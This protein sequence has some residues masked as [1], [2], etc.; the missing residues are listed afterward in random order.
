MFIRPKN[1]I[2][3]QIS[4][5]KNLLSILNLGYLPPV[6]QLKKI[7]F[8]ENSET[9]YLTELLFCKKSFLVQLKTILDKKIIF[10]RNYPY[11]SST[12]K[13]LRDN[14]T[15][16][17]NEIR[18]NFNFRKND[19]VV[20]I[21]SNDGNLLDKFKNYFQV[22]G[23]TPESIGKLA[24]KKGIPTLIRY[25]DS[26]AVNLIL[27][28]KG[29]ASII[30]ATNVFAHIDKVHSVVKQIKRLM[31]KD[32]IFVTESHY[33]LPLIKELQYDT[34]YH[35]HLRYY[36]LK[37]LNYLFKINNLEIFDA[38]KIPTHG[39]SIRVYCG[40]KG[41]YPIKPIVSKIIKEE[42]NF[43]NM[44]NLKNFNKKVF[45]SKIKLFSLLSRVFKKDI[46]IAG[47]SAPSRASTLINF[48]GLNREIIDC[49]FEIK[50]SK[51][52]G[53]YLPGTRIPILEEKIQDL[54]KYKYLIIFSWHIY[55]E[56]ITNLKK[57]G[58]KG[59]FIIPLPSPKII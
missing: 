54:K 30:T 31:E 32:S 28:K 50:G 47:I 2:K 56:I 45:L 39:G 48:I 46:K 26:K 19:L 24:I 23:V 36:S 38:K 13:I 49:I 57:K 33:V 18:N 52:I 40:F 14:F 11:T 59:K 9:K 4:G 12:T 17:Y 51:K 15:N 3:C 58:F 10:P 27:K 1:I 41:K 5:N 43:L 55:N 37:S 34:I 8:D 20:D 21:G 44:K 35:E 42:E 6:N 16:L 29:K 7:G 22:L 25:F 53:H